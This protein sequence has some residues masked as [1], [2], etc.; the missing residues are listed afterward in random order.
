VGAAEYER[1]S[2]QPGS[3]LASMDSQS[4]VHIIVVL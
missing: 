3:A 1:R 4:L 2:E